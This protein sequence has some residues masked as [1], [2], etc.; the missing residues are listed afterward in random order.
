MPYTDIFGAASAAPDNQVARAVR[1][2][3]MM[4]AALGIGALASVSIGNY[5]GG[6]LLALG[7]SALLLLGGFAAYGLGRGSLGSRLVLA[8]C[9]GSMVALYIHLG[10]GT[11]EFHFGVFVTLALLLVY[12]DWRPIVALAAFFAVHHVLFDRLQAAGVG[13]YCTPEPNFLKIVMHAGYVVV[14][15]SL[16]VFIAVTLGRLHREGEEM[17]TLVA[18]VNRGGQVNLDL[19][20]VTVTS[21]HAQQ[22][23][24]TID[25]MHLAMREVQGTADQIRT[26]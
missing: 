6:M 22:L 4:L 1:A 3:Q 14:Q 25:R 5:Y 18:A 9:L 7:G 26:A 11:L 20:H 12:L 15:T 10:R 17:S 8:I 13:V 23:K 24:A 21:A 2:D 16:E 19:G